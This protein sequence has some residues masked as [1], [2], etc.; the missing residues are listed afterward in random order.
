MKPKS[1]LSMPFHTRA[2][3]KAGNAYGRI[4]RDW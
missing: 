3:R 1:V 2:A 4:M